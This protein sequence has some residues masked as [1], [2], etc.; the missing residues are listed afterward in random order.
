MRYCCYLAHV[1]LKCTVLRQQCPASCQGMGWQQDGQGEANQHCSH[2]QKELSVWHKVADKMILPV[3]AMFQTWITSTRD[4]LML[5][6]AYRNYKTGHGITEKIIISL[7]SPGQTEVT[8]A[9]HLKSSAK[10]HKNKFII[11]LDQG[12][13]K[14]YWNEKKKRYYQCLSLEDKIF[15]YKISTKN[16]QLFDAEVERD[17]KK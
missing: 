17:E 8:E 6:F 10:L 7:P 11:Y 2:P 4:D 1:V 5:L 15:E 9:G 13:W 16:F 3:H 12:T 14:Y